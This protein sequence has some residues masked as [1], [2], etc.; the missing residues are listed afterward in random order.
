M[1][2]T[3]IRSILRSPYNRENWKNLYRNIFQNKVT[4][5]EFPHSYNINEDIVESLYQ[6]GYATLDDEYI[7]AL[8]EVNIKSEVN[9][10]SKKI[11]LR[12]VISKYISDDKFNGVLTIFENGSLDY[13]FTF[14]SKTTKVTESGIVVSETESKRYT[15]ILGGNEPCLTPSQ[16]FEGLF[17]K[18]GSI[19]LEDIKDAFSVEKLN[20]EFFN[21]YKEHYELFCDYFYTS[22]YKKTVFNDDEKMIRDF[23]KKFMGR[24]VFLYFV[25][26]KGWLGVKF[27]ENW[28]TGDHQFLSNLFNEYEEKDKFYSNILSKIF[29]E[30]LSIERTDDVIELLN[31]K[32]RIPY[33]NGGLFEKEKID[34]IK[35]DFKNHDLQSLFTFFDRFNFTIYEDDPNEHTVAVDPEMLGHIFENLL[36]DNKDKGAFY[37]PKEIVHYM[38]QESLIEYLTTWFKNKGYKITGYSNFGK[39]EVQKL[40]SENESRIGQLLIESNNVKTCKEI[41]RSIIENLLKKNFESIDKNLIIEHLKE[42]HIALDSVKICDPSIG[43]GAFPMGLLQEIFFTKQ[44]LWNFEFGNLNNFPSSEIK[45]NIIQNSIYGVDIEKGAVDIARLRFWLSLIVDEDEPK[46]LPNLDFKIVVG[47]S[48]VGVFENEV[49]EIDWDI[50][51]KN[52]D[53]VKKMILDQQNKLYQLEHSQHL[54]FQTFTDKVSLSKNIKRLKIEILK[55]QLNLSKNYFIENNPI[56]GGFIPSESENKKNQLNKSYIDRINNI[57]K[58]LESIDNDESLTYFDWK[59]NFP[60]IFNNK[61]TGEVGFDIIIGNPPYIGQSGN[62]DLFRVVLESEFGKKFHQ[63]RMDYF[64][65]FFHKS[66]SI[67]KDKGVIA[68][69]TTNYFLNSTYGDKL[70]KDLYENCEFIHLINFNESRVFESAL[71]QH[72]AISILVKEKNNDRNVRTV[73]TS[74]KGLIGNKELHNILYDNEISSSYFNFKSKDIFELPKYHILLEGNGEGINSNEKTNF[75]FKLKSNNNKLLDYVDII[76]GVVTG[77]ND[78]SEKYKDEYHIDANTGDG[79]FILQQDE[80]NMMKLNDY[81]LSFIKPWY[82][83]SDIR[84]YSS[85]H[86]TN[87]FIIYITSFDEI[88]INRIPNLIKHFERFKLLLL[89][90]N[91]RTGKYSLSDYERFVEGKFDIPYVMIKSSFKK[92]NYFLVSY[93]RDKNVFEGPKLICPQRSPVNCFAYNDISWYGATDVYFIKNKKDINI[94]LKYFLGIL[95]S[96]LIYFWLYNKGQRKGEI[97]QLFK[98]PLTEI[99]MLIGNKSQQEEIVNMVSEIENNIKKNN[100]IVDL[101]KNLNQYV[102]NLFNISESEIKIIESKTS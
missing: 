18:N 94:D 96:K 63:R 102:Y 59:L 91:V 62:R 78:L 4:F 30:F 39:P 34:E 17:K 65:F 66:V 44:T 83:N 7:V 28:G 36:E 6:I 32:I 23:V 51:F 20:K 92:G 93:S 48:L 12:K 64:Y 54:Y 98:D 5:F 67:C 99:P 101:E 82:K 3:E 16:R 41:D 56:L 79:I 100:D 2:S 69:I 15:Y 43:S 74:K 40:F 9:I 87:Q 42:F 19:K 58:K 68:F 81:E 29:F 49:I 76:Q 53:S 14:A 38:C 80:I 22:N 72:N 31:N 73:L 88:D 45:S 86:N 60:E 61:I 75:L 50:K 11:G 71:G 10:L 21:G 95:N 52:V 25:Q 26:K 89:N 24:I 97:L 90:R 27:N 77:A 57:I 46:S 84:R 85:N 33:L 70:R 55:N 37:T 13:R 1:N 8:F 47:N 35:I